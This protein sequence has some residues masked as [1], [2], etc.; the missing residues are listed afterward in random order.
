MPRSL[1]PTAALLSLVFLGSCASVD[2]AP[3]RL[4]TLGSATPP[5][6][7]SEQAANWHARM[8]AY[9]HLASPEDDAEAAR[10][11]AE[12]AA[13][14]RVPVAGAPVQGSAVAPVTIVEFAD[15]ECGFCVRAEKVL[16]QIRRTYG[17]AVR[18]VW[19]DEPLPFHDHAMAAAE[20][21]REARA[22][23][24][25]AG[26]WT[27]HDALLGAGG[28]LNEGAF[29][30]LARRLGLDPTKIAAA[31]A[32]NRYQDG[33]DDDLEIADDVGAEGTP[34]F[35]IN[36]RRLVGAQPFESFKPIVDAE[37]ANA[38]AWAAKGTSP[39]AVYDAIIQGGRTTPEPRSAKL[40]P[41]AS[42]PF[43]GSPDAPI[44]IQEFA[45][46]Q[47]PYCS[48]VEETLTRV[49]SRYGSRVKLVWRDLP[50]SMHEHAELAAEAAAEAKK[51]KGNLGFWAMH[52]KLLSNQR[53]P[54]ALERPA[55]V[56]YA[57]EIGLDAAAFENALDKRV[58]AAEVTIDAKAA[59]SVDIQ[60]TPA[61]LVG[62]YVLDG[63]QSFVKF[64]KLIRRASP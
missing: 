26:F 4:A 40:A 57:K 1:I 51:Q 52:D 27:A 29:D 55:L 22:E 15:F 43:R 30:L 31:I 9:R 5:S 54:H 36:G 37:I 11:A 48:R 45:D 20:F 35:F 53:S 32:Q 64:R 56:S 46:F 8:E 62:G 47:C 21:A 38:R 16:G 2:A 49:L 18:I 33:V 58:H 13:V 12:A 63:A 19:K 10:E 24:G 44:V 59:E 50:L 28:D 60:S 42:A 41:P 39:G 61:F 25:E 14:W 23:K 6:D 7:P 34:T 3:Q 17:D